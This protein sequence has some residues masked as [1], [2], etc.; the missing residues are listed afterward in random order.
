MIKRFLCIMAVFAI[1]A[2]VNAQAL[3]KSQLPTMGWSSWN[4]YHVNI[5]DSLIIKQANAMVKSGLK[6]AGYSYINIDDGYF[7]GRDS[8]TGRLL[9]HPTRFP[10]GLKTVVDHVHGLGLKAGIYS[11]AGANTCGCWYDNDTIAIGVGLYGHE[12]Q[13]CDLFFKELGFDFIKIDFCGGSAARNASHLA[14]D[15]KEQYTA[16]R[17]AIDRTGRRDVRVN[18]CRWD[19]PG[20]WVSQVADSWRMSHDIRARWSSVKDIIQQNLY[21]SAY[22]SPGHYNDMDMLEVGRGLKTEEDRTHF[23]IWCMMSS[24]LLIGCDITKLRPETLRLLTNKD[25]I[26]INQDTLGLQAYVAKITNNCYVLVKDIERRH[27]TK[28][29]FAVYNPTDSTQ[30]I[31]VDMTTLELGGKVRLRDLLE[32]KDLGTLSQGKE[33]KGTLAPHAT[34]VFLAECRERLP[35]E[36]YEAET[37]YLSSYQEL[38][39]PIAIGTAYYTADKQCSGEMKVTNLGVRPENDLQWRDVYCQQQGNHQVVVHTVGFGSNKAFYI[40]VNGGSAQLVN[41][42]QADSDGKV[43]LNLRFNKGQNSVR[44]YNDNAAMPD[45]D[46]ME[47]HTIK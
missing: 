32:Q 23:A 42:K 41:A 34:Q 37:A 3:G 6:E 45:I 17:K 25:L 14:L 11:D 4:T 20:T 30:T 5:S 40:S 44:L 9:I 27:G 21:L 24:P 19:Y 46:Y 28:R 12:Q 2:N 15:P 18:V 10:K 31:S 35:R 26:A 43:T 33:W 29:A 36:I 39:N 7:G 38:Y 16:I 13:D 47:I 8:K 1:Y 22:V